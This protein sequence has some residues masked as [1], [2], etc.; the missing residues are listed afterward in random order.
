M[1]I[2]RPFAF[3]PRA[4]SASMNYDERKAVERKLSLAFRLEQS[5]PSSLRIKIE[6]RL[7]DT[8]KTKARTMVECAKIAGRMPSRN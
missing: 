8:L 7:A 3:K 1:K 5:L 4:A 2:I 6:P